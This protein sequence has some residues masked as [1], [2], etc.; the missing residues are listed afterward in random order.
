MTIREALNSFYAD[1]GDRP[2]EFLIQEERETPRIEQLLVVMAEENEIAGRWQDERRN[3]LEGRAV[4]GVSDRSIL[5]L[6]IQ[7]GTLLSAYREM[8]GFQ[9]LTS[10]FSLTYQVFV[11]AEN[12]IADH[13]RPVEV[14]RALGREAIQEHESWL[15]LH[16]GKQIQNPLLKIK[17]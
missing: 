13:P 7:G 1:I 16:Q 17:R 4:E 2:L 5:S 10:N 8:M 14:I 3:A 6:L 12:S 15:L 9:E 11:T